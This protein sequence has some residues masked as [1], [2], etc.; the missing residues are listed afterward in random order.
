M[1]EIK[2]IV[3]EIKMLLMDLPRSR[4][5]TE[6]TMADYFPKLRTDAKPYIYKTQ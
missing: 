6:A 3:T 2:N 5:N 1:L 4:R